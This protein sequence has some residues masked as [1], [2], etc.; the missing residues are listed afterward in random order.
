MIYAFMK[1]MFN[2]EFGHF[3]INI[4]DNIWL[5]LLKQKTKIMI[6]TKWEKFLTCGYQWIGCEKFHEGGGIQDGLRMMGTDRRRQPPSGS[7]NSMSHG[8]P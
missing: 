6:W 5:I 7:G 4:Q 2:R 8:N 3:P 1:Q